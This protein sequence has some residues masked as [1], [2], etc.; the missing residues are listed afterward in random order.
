VVSAD[1]LVA[2]TDSQAEHLASPFPHWVHSIRSGH[3]AIPYPSPDAVE[4]LT[5]EQAA[6]VDDRIATRF[7]GSAATVA[8][9]LDGLQ[10][11]TGAKELLVTTIAYDHEDR[12]RSYELLAK[13]W[14]LPLL[15]EISTG[16]GAGITAPPL[17]R[18]ICRA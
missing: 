8:E 3:G 14:G 10:R 15:D 11:A 16:D 5:P 4:A 13:E 7:V 17:R 2:E 1:A 6:P 9:K 12:L 18:P